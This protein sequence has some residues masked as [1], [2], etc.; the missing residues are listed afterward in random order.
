MTKKPFSAEED[1]IIL[2]GQKDGL[3]W[4]DIAHQLTGRNADQV[5]FRFVNTINPLLMKNVA[6]TDEE[7]RI[8]QKAQSELGN[9]WSLIAPFLPG[10]SENDIKN[11]WHN[12]RL[13]A[14]RK[15]KSMAALKKRDET[16][17]NLRRGMYDQNNDPFPIGA[18][19]D[20]LGIASIMDDATTES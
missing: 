4:P 16:L 19:E 5:R 10:R 1:A 20:Y 17:M 9:K 18:T 7:E 3:N 11:H 14:K 8:L 2:Q 15:M 13:K 6:W 12:R